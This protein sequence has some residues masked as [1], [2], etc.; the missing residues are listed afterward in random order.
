MKKPNK[1][2]IS[3]FILI[4][5]I[6]GL[7]LFNLKEAGAA[8]PVHEIRLQVRIPGLSKECVLEVNKVPGQTNY[9]VTDFAEY[10]I[11]FYRYFV[12]VVGILSTVMVIAGGLLWIVAA[13]NESKIS[14]AKSTISGAVIGLILTLTSFIL[15]NT[16]SP[17]LVKLKF[18]SIQTV[19]KVLQS[20]YFCRLNPA[21]KVVDGQ[22]VNTYDLKGATEPICGKYYDMNTKAGY[23][24]Q[25]VGDFCGPGK[26][27]F[28]NKDNKIDCYPPED[29]CKKTDVNQCD[30]T[31]KLIQLAA[32]D[33]GNA[34]LKNKVCRRYFIE[35]GSDGC[36][37]YDLL[38]CPTGYTK[39]DCNFGAEGR[40]TDT[41]CWDVS[42]NEPRFT[43]T[44]T[45]WTGFT[46]GASNWRIATCTDSPKVAQW[47]QAVCCAENNK[48]NCRS[49]CNSDEVVVNC[50]S[51]QCS[52]KKCCQPLSSLKLVDK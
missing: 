52:G 22:T 8:D 11:Y 42:K 41:E 26:L 20:Q 25:C 19:K 7:G 12:G 10:V 45:F 13:G 1:K 32:N 27:C 3:I 37:L 5:V 24:G 23:S 4:V 30:N 34:D 50:S 21:R 31:D 51:G 40:T 35:R 43:R 18:P 33:P 44:A 2:I 47:A 16:I 46:L 38:S 14:S 49:E 36:W 48:I 28:E 6:I 9:C 29:A 39:V 17:Q 15:L